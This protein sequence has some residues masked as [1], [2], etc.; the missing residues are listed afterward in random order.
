MVKVIQVKDAASSEPQEVPDVGTFP[1][2]LSE[3]GLTEAEWKA[4][5]K[6]DGLPLE[7]IE[8]KGGE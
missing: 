5:I 4:R 8:T 1:Q 6:K 7:I 2:K 3:T